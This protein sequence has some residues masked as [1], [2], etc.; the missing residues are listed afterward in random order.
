MRHTYWSL[1]VCSITHTF[2][3]VFTMM[4]AA[5]IP[6]FAHLPLIFS[7]VM[8]QEMS[9]YMKERVFD[10]I[11]IGN[12]SWD[13]QGGSGFIGPYTN[14]HTG[15]HVSARE[16]ALLLSYVAQRSLE[17]TADHS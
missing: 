3:H 14:A 12:L 7:N 10:P 17:R 16:L 4:H 8:K 15:I 1:F 13:V 11:G 9:D 2:I 5:L 6:V